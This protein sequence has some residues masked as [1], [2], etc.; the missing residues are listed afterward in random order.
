MEPSSKPRRRRS[1]IELWR[2]VL[3]VS[4]AI[5]FA[6]FAF[7]R[8][9][10]RETHEAILTA[11]RAIDINHA[12]LQRDVLQARA[13]LLRN[14]DPLAESIG[15][16]HAAIARL[17]M[18]FPES[19]VETTADL[20]VELGRLS[21]SIDRDEQLVE[22]FKTDNAL[23]QNSL[24][25]ANQMLSELHGGEDEPTRSAL[26]D[27]PDLG[28]LMLRFASQ[29]DDRL[30]STIRS[31]LDRLSRSGAGTRPDV[32]SY[33]THA[34]MILTILPQVDSTIEAIQQSQTSTE[35]QAL[36]SEYLDG[37]GMLSSQSAWSR[38]LLGS[39]SALLCG[40][41]AV[42]IYRLRSQTHKLTQQL[43]FENLISDIKKRFYEDFDTITDAL[44]DSLQMTADF[45]DA[46]Q[47]AFAVLNS[48]TGEI[49]HVSGE[50]DTMSFQTLV[51]RFSQGLRS[52]SAEEKIQWDRFY[53]DNLQQ[54]DLHNLPEGLLSAG[55][56]AASRIGEQSIGLLFLEHSQVRRKPEADEVRLLGNAV[57]TLAQCI[58]THR[59][60][61]E[62]NAL[63]ARLEHSQR[64]EAVGTLA[65]G[66]AH[67]FNN[68][69]GAILGYGEMALQI[70]RNANQTRRYV[71]EM[72]S[73]GQRAKHIIDQILTFSRKR[74]RISQ[75]F[76]LAEAVRDIFPLIRM[77]LPPTNNVTLSEES[78]PPVLGNPIELQQ[79]LMNLCTNAVQ[80]C[81][82]YGEV[83][84]DVSS[85]DLLGRTYLSHG[86]L[87][88]GR[89]TVLS[90]TD[91]GAGIP[92]TVLPHIFEPFY[93]TKAKSGG[94]GLGLAAVHGY[95][96]GM[97]GRIDIESRSE[98][99]T[100]FRLYFPASARKAIPL[101][102][103]FNERIL[104]RG[105]GETILIGQRESTVRLLHEDKIA[106]LGYEPV[107]LS[108][109][110]GVK[111]WIG[112]NTRLPD[113][114]I[115]DLDLWTVKPSLAA[116]AAEFAPVPT[117]F[118]VDP[119][120]D[121][122]DPRFVSDYTI[123]RK[124]VSAINLASTLSK[125]IDSTTVTKA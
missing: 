54:S 69:L 108:S 4:G 13:G 72:V 21:K 107:G 27:S 34:K 93:T 124:P 99:G 70:R 78:V 6:L 28:N 91:N 104:N 33:V 98:S 110:G 49:E 29:P 3:I 36:Q 75:P 102:D 105:A 86:E 30:E 73:S 39:I 66:I 53:Y 71:Q 80:A 11:L 68:A 9:P 5:A 20:T 22:Q 113:L 44:S 97:N 117:I 81:G 52:H 65:G 25:I 109:L 24:S 58:R 43:D 118:M 88:A 114:I 41:V 8:I 1:T 47:F 82:E 48:Q 7:W 125:V 116:I 95:V 19:G 51:E 120:R 74:D 37:Y 26:A 85:I 2:I 46:G 101:S 123:L 17:S 87:G 122:V 59:D 16:L 15:N 31:Q 61:E 40:Y 84:V 38:L 56:L 45:F 12:S 35:A 100:R 50:S 92:P 23:L 76:D 64:L 121:T 115:L 57:V 111:R 14:Y 67:E 94:T 83:N 63:E 106:A 96:S 55:S 112:R 89:Y 77:S 10:S 18:L 42:L 60:R 32:R 62:R 90:V 119:Q 103:F 79:V